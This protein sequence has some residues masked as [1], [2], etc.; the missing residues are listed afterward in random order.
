MHLINGKKLAAHLRQQLTQTISEQRL[1]PRLDIFLIGEDPASNLYVSLKEKGAQEVGMELIVHR[2]AATTSDDEIVRQ[3]EIANTQTE[4]D[5][6]LVQLPLPDEHDTQRIINAI[7]PSKDVDGFHPTNTQ[8]L[9]AGQGLVISPTHEAILRLIAQTSLRLVDLQAAV[10]ANS[11][12]FA[13]PLVSLLNRAGADTKHLQP[14][15]LDRAWLSGCGLVICAVGKA[16][17]LTADMLPEARV[18]IDVGTNTNEQG[19]P[20]GDV[21]QPSFESTD[22]WLSP[23]PGGVGPM[24]VALLLTH[25]TEF[26]QR[27]HHNSDSSSL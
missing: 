14:E 15:E 13:E 23:V 9:L 19:M 25:V 1:H 5:A 6:I 11:D 26:H 4:T 10:I 22:V 8:A 21:D 7:N 12:T 17:F 24:T 27:K 20:C 16:K 3:I 18:V 2:L